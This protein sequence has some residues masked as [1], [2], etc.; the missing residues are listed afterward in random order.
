MTTTYTQSLGGFDVGRVI[1]RTFGA[2]GENWMVFL[3][4]AA[5]LVGL[6]SLL[7][8][9]GQ[10]TML[11]GIGSGSGGWFFFAGSVLTWIGTYILQGVVLFV[12][13]SRLNGKSVDISQAFAAGLRFFFPILGVS[14]LTGLG[15]ALGM[16]LLVVPG[17]ILSIMWVVAVPVVVAEKVGVMG[18]LQR[19]RDLTRGNRWKIF[20]LIVIAAS[21]INMA[22]GG[23]G[24][25][26]AGSVATPG[27]PAALLAVTALVAVVTAVISAAGAA[28]IYYELRSS[29]EGVGAE[30]I[31]SVF[32]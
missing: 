9:H 24:G 23:V 7:S 16:I 2:I 11:D 8:S 15:V 13:I 29:K 14:I 10:T 5:I 4:S 28:L 22:L 21:V 18:S 1:Q 19:S 27:A 17:I 20:G 32:D 31:A 30:Q 12:T 26:M 3:G 6:P 25:A